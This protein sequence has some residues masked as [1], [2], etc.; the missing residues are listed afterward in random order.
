MLHSFSENALTINRCGKACYP[1]TEWSRF[2]RSV[3]ET[4]L[5]WVQ[6][7]YSESAVS[8]V[9]SPAAVRPR[10]GLKSAFRREEE[11]KNTSN[12]DDYVCWKQIKRTVVVVFFLSST[13]QWK[14]AGCCWIH[15]FTTLFDGDTNTIELLSD[16]ST[17][18]DSWW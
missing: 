18:R 13:I 9:C 5:R 1:A 10:A 3:F 15:T 8:T 7:P 11:E 14:Q 2:R 4:S 12:C 16:S 6:K 17:I